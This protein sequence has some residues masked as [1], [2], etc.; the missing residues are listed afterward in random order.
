MR[1][2][3]YLELHVGSG[4]AEQNGNSLWSFVWFLQRKLKSRIIKDARFA[5]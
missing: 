5:K 1:I 2:F 3:F 4:P